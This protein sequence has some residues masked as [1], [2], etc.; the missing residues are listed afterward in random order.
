MPVQLRVDLTSFHIVN[1]L[2]DLGVE[3]VTLPQ[4]FTFNYSKKNVIKPTMNDFVIEHWKT[5]PQT[6]SID[7]IT[8]FRVLKSFLGENIPWAVNLDTLRFGAPNGS[9]SNTMDPQNIGLIPV[10]DA[11]YWLINKMALDDQKRLSDLLG[12]QTR[13]EIT[14]RLK[15]REDRVRTFI[16]YNY[17]IYEVMFNSVSITRTSKEVVYNYTLNF[18]VLDYKNV[19]DYIFKT[20]IGKY[21]LNGIIGAEVLAEL[22]KV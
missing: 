21:V 2:F 13:T 18:S 7:G 11:A 5:P 17:S 4:R 9:T 12:L 16:Y 14:A 19:Y 8:R 22:I 10:A 6:L 15:G 20:K 1:N 3:F